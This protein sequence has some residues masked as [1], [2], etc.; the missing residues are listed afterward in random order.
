[1]ALYVAKF[2]DVNG[3]GV[4]VPLAE[5]VRTYKPN[6]MNLL[7]RAGVYASKLLEL[8]YASPRE[9]NTEGGYSPQSSVRCC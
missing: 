1:M 4:D 3:R 5:I 8:F 9:S 2:E 7:E 6:Q